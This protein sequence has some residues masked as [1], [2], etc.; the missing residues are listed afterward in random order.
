[1]KNKGVIGIIFYSLNLWSLI[2]VNFFRDSGVFWFWRKF[3]RCRYDEYVC[4]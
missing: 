4:G 1:M 3:G 2:L